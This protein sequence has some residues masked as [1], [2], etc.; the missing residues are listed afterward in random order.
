MH[1][2]LKNFKICIL[3]VVFIVLLTHRSY[4]RRQRQLHVWNTRY[5][6]GH[7]GSSH[8]LRLRSRYVRRQ[9]S[10]CICRSRRRHCLVIV[11]L[12]W[13]RNHGYSMTDTDCINHVII[14]Y[15]WMVQIDTETDKSQFDNFAAAVADPERNR[16]AISPPL[17]SWIPHCWHAEKCCY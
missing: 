11:S 2:W 14:F 9:R 7:T 13:Q 4:T 5:T 15:W 10:F 1:N 17:L 12:H 3:S 16:V 8:S 6:L